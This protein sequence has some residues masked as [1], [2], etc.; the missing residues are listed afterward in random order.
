MKKLYLQPTTSEVTVRC[1]LNLLYSGLK[2]MNNQE[3]YPEE[4]LD[5]D[6]DDLP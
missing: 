4:D 3:V 2:D 5:D 1:E 6:Y